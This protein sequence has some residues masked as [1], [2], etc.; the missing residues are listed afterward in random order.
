MLFVTTYKVKPFL[1]TNETK[2]LM[3]VFGRVGAGEGTIAHYLAADGSH[4]LVISELEDMGAAYRNILNFTQWV[5]YETT[6]VLTIEEAAV[7]I[8]DAL[9]TS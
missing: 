1:S 8:M 7:Q 9:A 3:E 2:E 5:Q 6:P 4:G